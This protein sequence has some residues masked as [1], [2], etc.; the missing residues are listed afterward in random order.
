MALNDLS[1]ADPATVT[2]LGEAAIVVIIALVLTWL[3]HSII[4]RL[5]RHLSK[6]QPVKPTIG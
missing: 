1:F 6:A 5:L 4:F 2:S 3:G